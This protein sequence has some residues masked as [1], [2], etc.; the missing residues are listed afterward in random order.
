MKDTRLTEFPTEKIK[1]HTIMIDDEPRKGNH[2]NQRQLG[3]RRRDG[4]GERV[5][6]IKTNQL[7]NRESAESR[8][9]Q[10]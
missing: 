3:S 10:L 2:K 7:R 4:N 6:I 8:V 9:M 1:L 5:T